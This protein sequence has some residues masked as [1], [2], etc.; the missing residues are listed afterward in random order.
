MPQNISWVNVKGYQS[1]TVNG[2]LK[3]QMPSKHWLGS[4]IPCMQIASKMPCTHA[5][6][7][8]GQV[9]SD[10][11]AEVVVLRGTEWKPVSQVDMSDGDCDCACSIRHNRPRQKHL[12]RVC[13]FLAKTCEVS[14]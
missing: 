3:G 12:Q 7:T 5:A 6:S 9:Q 14:A 11:Q 1:V 2:S 4:N 10:R 13:R 8:G